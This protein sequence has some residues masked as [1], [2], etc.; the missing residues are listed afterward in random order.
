MS[1]A[2]NKFLV[3][4]NDIYQFNISKI[5]EI[6]P[7]LINQTKTE[8]FEAEGLL[9]ISSSD[10]DF[11]TVFLN[12]D[13]SSGMM[14]GNGARCAVRY[15]YDNSFF[16]RKDQIKFEMSG[17]IYHA[18]ITDSNVSVVFPPPVKIIDNFVIESNGNPYSGVYIDVNSDHFVIN[19][20]KLGININDT[21]ALT[22]LGRELRYNEAF[23]EKGSNINFYLNNND[24]IIELATYERGVEKI[25][26]A[27]GTGAIS[28]AIASTLNKL[29]HLPIKLV[30]PSGSIIEVKLNLNSTN[31]IESVDLKGN[32]EYN[33]EIELSL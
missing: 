10:L 21:I 30:P 2:G 25:T 28:T 11:L 29:S 8:D 22:N 4:N 3:I 9:L 27:C 33:G 31:N 17:N 7:K 24:G 1:G 26:G 14:C 16:N 19:L 13:G 15:A 5:S 23:G 6:T 18:S 12:P 32:A 20:N